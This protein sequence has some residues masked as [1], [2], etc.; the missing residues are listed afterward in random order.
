MNLG[1]ITKPNAKGQIV[2]PKR[3]RKELGIDE[4]VLL[5]LTIKGNG[6]YISLLDKSITT[7]DSRDVSMEIL[8]RTAGAWAGDDWE[9]T[10]AKRRIIEHTASKKRKNAW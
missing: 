2:I 3:F 5:H 4:D 7:S 10:E 6:L 8:K 9:K 1:T